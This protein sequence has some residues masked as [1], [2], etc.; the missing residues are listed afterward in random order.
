GIDQRADEDELV[1]HAGDARDQL[2]DLDPRHVRGNRV[3]LP[4]DFARR[5][6]L[7]VPHVHVRRTAGQV[8]IDDGLVLTA[9][10][11]LR[12]GPQQRGQRQAAED[13]A[14]DG[15]KVAAIK[16]VAESAVAVW[17]AE[18]REHWQR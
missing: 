12:L 2:A 10:A 8:D 18:D 9:P 5:L 14:A 15:E 11:L 17:L 13:R 1:G 6:G 4:A 16:A 3:E 7:D